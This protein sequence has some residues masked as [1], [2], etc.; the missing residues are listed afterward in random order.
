L[1]HADEFTNGRSRPAAVTAPDVTVIIPTRNRAR[2]L[3]GCLEATLAQ[4]DVELEV[5]VV[6]DGSTDDTVEVLARVPDQRLRV[7]SL[8]QGGG[9]AKARNRAIAEARGAWVAFL[10]DDDVWAPRKLRWQLDEALANDS[11]FVYGASVVVDEQGTIIRYRGAPDPGELLRALLVRNVIP[12]GCSNVMARTDLVRAVGGFDEALAQLADRDLWIRLAE[13]SSGA[14]CDEVMV[15]YRQHAGNMS[16]QRGHEGVSEFEYLVEKY[17]PSLRR[18]GIDAGRKPGYRYF[19][20][21]QLQAGRRG[22]SARIFVSLAVKERSPSDLG[23]ALAALTLGE[24]VT[25]TIHRV[26]PR[27]RPSADEI[28]VLRSRSPEELEWLRMLSNGGADWLASPNGR[29]PERR[30][31]NESVSAASE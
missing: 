12:G 29:H 15:A 30:R 4:E 5:I 9:V 2:F 24:G 21:T 26:R 17:G 3:A 27:L 31:E 6:D 13:A 25:D 18:Q 1:R 28:E 20:R 7:I 19:A 11:G 22:A 10:D 14:A 23:R 16:R 8:R